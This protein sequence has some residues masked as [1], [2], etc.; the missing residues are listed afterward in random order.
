MELEFEGVPPEAVFRL[1]FS[2]VPN[3]ISSFAVVVAS[4]LRPSFP[5]EPSE[6]PLTR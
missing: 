5:W 2:S 3:L 4:A 1:K 6:Q